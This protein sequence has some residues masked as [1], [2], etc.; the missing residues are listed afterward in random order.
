MGLKG[1]LVEELTS[2]KMNSSQFF[3][4]IPEDQAAIDPLGRPVTHLA[5]LQQTTGE[6]LYIDDYVPFENELF[7]V[8]VSTTRAPALL[9]KVDPS[10]ALA[11]EGVETFFSAKDI[12]RKN[13]SI[14]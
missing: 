1:D 13:I 9:K 5:C 2:Y 8:M 11:M 6:A 4:N 7:A 3:Q 14:D 10:L 12:E